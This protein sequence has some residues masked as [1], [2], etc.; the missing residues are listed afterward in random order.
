[1]ESV[2]VI[3]INITLLKDTLFCLSFMHAIS[4]EL[5]LIPNTHS[6]GNGNQPRRNIK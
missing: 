2:V 6:H 1:M 4:H 5:R 3:L